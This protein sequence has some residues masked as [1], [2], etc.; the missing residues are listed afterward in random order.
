M[1]EKAV[2]RFWAKVDRREPSECWEW[3]RARDA[4]GYGAVRIGG[5]LYKSH[6]LAF[7]IANGN[8]PVPGCCHHCDNPACV[9]PAHLFQGSQKQNMQDA[10]SKGRM[11]SGEQHYMRRHP[12]LRPWGDRNGMRRRKLGLT[13]RTA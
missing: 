7:F 10:S 6:R 3:R 12:E 2:A 13:S 9:N 4:Y 1:D 8:W 11:Q 5:K